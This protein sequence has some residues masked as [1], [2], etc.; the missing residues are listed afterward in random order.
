MGRVAPGVSES[1]WWLCPND[2]PCP[3]VGVVHDIADWD[4]PIPTCCVE[5][6]RCGKG[7]DDAALRVLAVIRDEI[8][9]QM[10]R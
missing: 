5:G 8:R 3:H 9:E 10:G 2:P 4:D 1:G 6:C 7:A